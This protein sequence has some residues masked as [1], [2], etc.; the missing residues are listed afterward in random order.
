MTKFT[1]S[2]RCVGHGKSMQVTIPA[3][4]ARKLPEGKSIR[5]ELTVVEDG[6]HYRYLGQ[7]EPIDAVPDVDVP[8]VNGDA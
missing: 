3:A 5:W 7:N 1:V 6:L 8:W 4:V 2:S